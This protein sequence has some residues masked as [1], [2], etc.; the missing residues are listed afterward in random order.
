MVMWKPPF[1]IILKPTLKI[2]VKA[3]LNS[4]FKITLKSRQNKTFKTYQTLCGVR[5]FWCNL[6]LSVQIRNSGAIT[7]SRPKHPA[8]TTKHWPSIYKTPVKKPT[9]KSFRKAP[10]TPCPGGA[11]L[12]VGM[13]IY[14]TFE[15]G[16][17]TL[18]S[19]PELFKH[20]S[21]E[22]DGMVDR[23]SPSSSL[24]EMVSR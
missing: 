20:V 4:I 16:Y 18:Q 14:H 21:I 13:H 15:Q 1:V 22:G 11:V 8:N 17:V 23:S 24:H 19:A 3:I 6:W 9:K 5:S 7:G 12:D 10:R 2:I